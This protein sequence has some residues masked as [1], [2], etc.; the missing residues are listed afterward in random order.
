MRNLYR[1]QCGQFLHQ[2][3]V[4]TDSGVQRRV[5]RELCVLLRVQTLEP[6]VF[7]MPVDIA[8][9]FVGDSSGMPASTLECTRWMASGYRRE[10]DLT[11]VREIESCFH[12]HAA[13]LRRTPGEQRNNY[14]FEGTHSWVDVGL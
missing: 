12:A 7:I 9:S 6:T 2:V 5:G 4:S 11:R 13:A 14:L 1:Q 10:Y 3:L 8:A